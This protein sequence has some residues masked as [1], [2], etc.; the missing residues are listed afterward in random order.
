[1]LFVFDTLSAAPPCLQQLSPDVTLKHKLLFTSISFGLSLPHSLQ[2]KAR[3]YCCCCVSELLKDNKVLAPVKGL[4]QFL[5]CLEMIGGVSSFP[6]QFCSVTDIYGQ[7]QG[8]SCKKAHL[9][10][11]DMWQVVETDGGWEQHQ[12][13]SGFKHRGWSCWSFILEFCHHL[14]SSSILANYFLIC[15]ISL[16]SKT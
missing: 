6:A 8:Q 10:L 11:W 1:M 13:L 4:R 5:F 14:G 12:W 7:L 9:Y 2:F 15:S 16:K 3:F